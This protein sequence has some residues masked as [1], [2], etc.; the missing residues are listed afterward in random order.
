MEMTKIPWPEMAA[1]LY[2]T[3]LPGGMEVAVW[4]RPGFHRKY[5]AFGTHFGAIDRRFRTGGGEPVE[6]PAGIAHFLEH[7]MFEKPDQPVMDAFSALG[8]DPNAYTGT[9]YTIYLFSAVD[10]FEPALDTLIRY[11]QEGIFTPASVAKQKGIIEQEIRMYLDHPSFMVYA[12]LLQAMYK[13]HPIRDYVAGTVESIQG[14]TPAL[15]T[16]CHKTFYDP[17][18]MILC[19]VG[20]V[21]PGAVAE[22]A[23][24]ALQVPSGP[25]PAVERFYPDEPEGVVEARVTREMPVSRPYVYVGFKGPQVDPTGAEGM[26][27]EIMASFGLQALFGEAT[28][29]YQELYQDGTITEGFGAGYEQYPKASYVLMGGQSEHP[30]RFVDKTFQRIEKFYHEGLDPTGFERVRRQLIGNLPALLDQ[31]EGLAH[32]YMTY[33]F[34]DW[35]LLDVARVIRTLDMEEVT[36]FLRSNLRLEAASVSTVTPP[37]STTMAA[38]GGGM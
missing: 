15:L 17:R 29:W 38:V 24:R 14:I 34:W 7:E 32:Q 5:A 27:R 8:A 9:A 36:R 12:N 13:N 16:Q 26:R 6:M 37:G 4:P 25:P 21:E 20:D 19:V 22:L 11:V 35:D 30:E 28:A 1:E 23:A 10:N 18:R 2:R 31:P 33:R 3:V